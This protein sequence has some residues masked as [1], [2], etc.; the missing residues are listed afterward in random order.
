M[1]DRLAKVAQEFTALI[2]EES[3]TRHDIDFMEK[4]LRAAL[5]A[6]LKLKAKADKST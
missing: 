5:E 4:F 6:T 2:K 3:F 1:N